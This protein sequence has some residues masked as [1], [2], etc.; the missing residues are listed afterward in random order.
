MQTPGLVGYWPLGEK[1]GTVACDGLGLRPGTYTGSFALG[2]TGAIASSTDTATRFYG[3][4]GHVSVPHA[5]AFD[6]GDAFTA[7]AWVKR[8]TVSSSANQSILSRSSAWLLM[9]NSANRIVL[10]RSSGGDVAVSSVAITD[11]TGF[12]HVVA[13]KSGAT[14]RLYLD[15]VDVTGTVAHQTLGNTAQPVYVGRSSGGS[16]F[17][18]TIDEPALYAS[19][20]SAATV[21]EHFRLGRAAPAAD[22][23]VAAAGDI[24]CDPAATAFNGGA[25]TS[26]ECRQ[27][28]VSDLLVGQGL[29][30]VLTLGDHQYEDDAYAKYLKSFDPSWGRVKSLIRP[31]IGDHEYRTPGAAG[32]FDYFNGVGVASGAAGDR[33]KAYYS[34]DVGAWHLVVLN[35]NCTQV[36]GCAAGSAQERWLRADLAANPR[37]CTL[38][39]FHHPRFTGGRPGNATSVTPLWQALYDAG[40]EVVL[41]GHVHGYERFA[42]QTPGGSL[43][44]ARGIR[45]F[46]VGT[47]G[48]SLHPF[49]TT[50]PNT[51]VRSNTSFGVLKLTLRPSSYDWRFTPASGSTFTDSGT[52]ACH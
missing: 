36:G 46:V 11:T 40:A 49:A 13:T 23:V 48:K 7:E 16:Y 34:Y 39:Y 28:A 42:P 12:H 24:A 6:V 15:G 17:N 31:S 14:V 18:G 35:S 22:P 19:A 33:T 20:L 2:R 9:I 4:T 29:A 21:A 41:G 37:S 25:G 52:Q 8:S 45:E 5:A 1:A 43:D 50:P 10:R 38:A 47:G 26:T 32:Y 27:R 51:E 3:T 44:R 30:R